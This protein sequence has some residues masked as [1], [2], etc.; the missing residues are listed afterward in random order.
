MRVHV[1]GSAAGGGFPQWNCN[2]QN[3]YGVRNGKIHAIPRT[4]S[5]IAVSIDG[6]RWLLINASPDIRAQ[7]EASTALQPKRGLRD[8]GIGAVV[9]VDSQID[10]SSGLL[11]LREGCPFD[12]YASRMVHQDLSSGFPIFPML[13]SWNGGINYC[14]L[15]IDGSAVTPVGF[16]GLQITAVPICGKAPPYSPHRHDPHPGD[17]VALYI[18]DT[19]SGKSIFYAPGLGGLDESV[20]DYMIS[21]DCLLVDGTFW[22]EDEMIFAGVGTKLAKEMGHLPQSG[23]GGMIEMLRC[24]PEQRK[25]LIHINNTNPILDE[26][27]PERAILA[28][29]GIEVAFDGLEI[30]LDTNDSLLSKVNTLAPDA[31]PTLGSH[32]LGKQSVGSQRAGQ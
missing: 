13:E 12:V 11:M 19:R 6:D 24:F 21:A 29:E 14:E 17:N 31:S 4:Q 8:T 28:N 25:I 32:S 30:D 1:L 23:H 26:N 10:H 27:S 7:L 20:I 3:C 16:E 5:S 2:C 9:L 15:A 18:Q 22:R